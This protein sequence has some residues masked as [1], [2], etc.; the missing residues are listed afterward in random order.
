[1]QAV[2]CTSNTLEDALQFSEVCRSQTP[3]IPFIYGK[4]AGVFGQVF[5]DFGSHFTITDTDGVRCL[6]PGQMC[7]CT[8]LI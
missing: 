4:T 3:H 6:D 8:Q 1:M 2:V 5:C 7:S